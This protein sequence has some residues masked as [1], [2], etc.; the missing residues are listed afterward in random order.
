MSRIRHEF[1]YKKAESYKRPIIPIS[2]KYR[3]KRTGYLTLIDSG[4]DF[5]IFHA[6]IAEVLSIDLNKL[7]EK[8]FG[9]IKKDGLCTGYIA[10][11]EIGIDN[12]FFEYPVLFSK[13]IAPDGY[14]ILGQRGFFEKYKVTLDYSTD[15][16]YLRRS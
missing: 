1:K 5:C 14:G 3:K 8:K 6:D 13:E 4:A 15:N 16:I 10:I 2:I 9:G 12:E 11:V 7:P